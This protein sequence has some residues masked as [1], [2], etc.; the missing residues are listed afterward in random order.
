[1]PSPVAIKV[2]ADFAASVRAAA[3]AADRSL[4]GQI[5]HWAKIGRATEAILPAQAAAALKRCAGDLDAIE[6][7]AM[8]QRV[9]NALE[10]LRSGGHYDET[11]RFLVGLGQPL[12][13][14]DPDDPNG[15]IQVQANG[16]RTKGRIVGR[17]FVPNA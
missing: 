8:R 17:E 12:F 16:T 3:E 9:L 11:R 1:M 10:A 14:A 5:E 2:S 6:D 4:T 13:E 7:P 15:I